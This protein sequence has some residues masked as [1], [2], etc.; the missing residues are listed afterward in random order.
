MEA[1]HDDLEILRPAGPDQQPGK[2]HKQ[3]VERTR[4][5]TQRPPASPQINGHA[6]AMGTHRAA[7]DPEEQPGHEMRRIHKSTAGV[8]AGHTPWTSSGTHTAVGA[9]LMS[10]RTPRP[11]ASTDP[12]P[13]K[14]ACVSPLGSREHEVFR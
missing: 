8:C 1:Q 4:R 2:A 5:I 11:A 12:A 10:V 13:G 3:A 6:R 7:G 9:I 14:R